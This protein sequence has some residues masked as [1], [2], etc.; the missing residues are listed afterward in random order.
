MPSGLNYKTF[1][2]V[3]VLLLVAVFF[4][5][6][7]RLDQ[8]QQNNAVLGAENQVSVS[9]YIRVASMTFK[10]YP[11]KRIPRIGN[12]DTFADVV[13][14][15]CEDPDKTYVFK[16]IPTDTNGYGTVTFPSDVFTLD[17][18]YRVYVRG[19]SHLNRR[20]NCYTIN[21]SNEFIDLTLEGKE[22][23]AGETSSVYDNYIN[24]LDMSVLIKNMF[25]DDYKSDLNQDGKVNSLDFAN[26]IFNLFMAGD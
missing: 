24:S 19:Y 8:S 6:K 12:W 2:V 23:L 18:P 14:V 20:Y 26:Q 1:T 4:V 21:H 11:E 5:I 7:I 10:V 17:A 3:A 13:L 16:N 25:T 22:L 15:N 9:G